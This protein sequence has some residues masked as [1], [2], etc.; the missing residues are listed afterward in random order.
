MA[1]IARRRAEPGQRFGHGGRVFRSLGH[2]GDREIRAGER[3]RDA[4]ADALLAARDQRDAAQASNSRRMWSPVRSA[5]AATV[6][7]GL[8]AAEVGSALASAT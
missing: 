4:E 6:S 8:T 2:D 3:L 1:E 7:A 5:I